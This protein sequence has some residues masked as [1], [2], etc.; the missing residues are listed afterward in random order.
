MVRLTHP[1]PPR[2]SNL[3]EVYIPRKDFAMMVHFGR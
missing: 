3:K 2:S 1:F